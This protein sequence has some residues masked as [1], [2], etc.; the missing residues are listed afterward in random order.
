MQEPKINRL[1]SLG[2]S[3]VA[4]EAICD[5]SIKTDVTIVEKMDGFIVIHFIEE[6]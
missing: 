4:S 1:I 3:K 5:G 2:Q 6:K